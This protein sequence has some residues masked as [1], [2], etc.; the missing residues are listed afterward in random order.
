MRLSPLL[1]PMAVVACGG[2]VAAS[3]PGN[4]ADSS[5]GAK[6]GCDSGAATPAVVF[7]G[8]RFL[9]YLDAHGDRLVVVG[10][11]GVF[12]ITKDCGQV[13]ML[14]QEVGYTGPAWSSL[15]DVFWATYPDPLASSLP[16]QLVKVTAAGGAAQ[17]FET[18]VYGQL[19]GI[20]GDAE[21][22]YTATSG[23]VFAIP[24]AGGAVTT[25][26]SGLHGAA[27][28]GVAVGGG[29]LFYVDESLG[30]LRAVPIHGGPVSTVYAIGF[31]LDSQVNSLAADAT[32]VYWGTSNGVLRMSQDGG[33]PT[34]LLTTSGAAWVALDDTF[35]YVL[36]SGS[37]AVGRLSKAGGAQQVLAQASAG[38]SGLI[39]DTTN[40]YWIDGHGRTV[41]K[42]SK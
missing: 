28:G 15:G 11:D 39:S 26:A 34:T 32:A 9:D 41:M 5:E 13:V 29:R 22:L 33:T 1:I 6:A 14:G 19:A 3:P 23:G 20:S 7:Q 24:L 38:A 25:L 18:P 27:G 36:D 8:S 2:Q 10:D 17:S 40:L 16:M 31:N 4:D 35:V 21:N 37:G 30:A 12:S 42:V